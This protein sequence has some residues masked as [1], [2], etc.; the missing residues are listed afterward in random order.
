MAIAPFDVAISQDITGIRFNPSLA[1]TRFMYYL[2][3]HEANY[4]FS[5]NQGTS[6][7]G[8]K[9]EDLLALE[10]EVT[11]TK[12]QAKIAQVLAILDRAIAQTG[13]LLA[14]QQRVKVGLMQ[15]LLTGGIDADGNRRDSRTHA[16]KDSRLGP[17]PVE[18]EV[19][20]IGEIATFVGSG[21][22][23]T[24]GSSVYV[25][26][27]VQFLRSQ[28]IHFGGLKLD[29]VA[30]ISDT[31][32]TVMKRSRVHPFDVLLNITGA[33]IGRC[34][35]YPPEQGRANVNQHVCIIRYE[36]PSES[37]AIF[38][39]AF[40][41]SDYGQ[42]QIKALN[43]GGNREGLNYQQVRAMTL[44]YPPL[45]EQEQIATVVVKAA[46]V[47]RDLSQ[48][49]AKMQLLRAGLMQDLLTGRVSVLPLLGESV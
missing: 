48:Q 21:V 17:I 18:W 27:G 26:A 31:I 46:E 2:L 20:P 29:D 42:R 43:A 35:Y 9:R 28:N 45:P 3:Q 4:F 13:A 16:F 22:T 36:A 25:D 10:V 12:S 15:E 7:N 14:K 40:L 49:H 5:L 34:C 11:D 39:S 47:G 41:A 32:D 6:I 24:G 8:V 19:K 30:Y 38:L 1:D 44:A 37:T 23:P 33:S